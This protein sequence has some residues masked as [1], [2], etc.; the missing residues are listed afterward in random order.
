MLQYYRIMDSQ[1]TKYVINTTKDTNRLYI[2]LKFRAT[3][4]TTNNACV[5]HSILKCNSMCT[6]FLF[7]LT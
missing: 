5:G 4:N 2:A 3:N 1:L 6:E 7:L